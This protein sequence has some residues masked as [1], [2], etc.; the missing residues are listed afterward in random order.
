MA[1]TD[2]GMSD[3][4]ISAYLDGELSSDERQAVERA[5]QQ[6]AACRQLYDQLRALR[7]SLQGLP[8]HELEPEFAARV[9]QRI[10]EIRP[11][12]APQPAP[13]PAPRGFR[14]GL[15]WAAVAIA[16]GVAVMLL[17]PPSE[18]E[19]HHVVQ[20]PS[21]KNE[22]AK[23]P[24]SVQP[25]DGASSAR[26]ADLAGS[27]EVDATAV[28]PQPQSAGRGMYR[29]EVPGPQPAAERAPGQAGVAADERLERLNKP[30]APASRLGQEAE[31]LPARGLVEFKAQPAQPSDDPTVVPSVESAAARSAGQ[32]AAAGGVSFSTDPPLD[33]DRSPAGLRV[34]VTDKQLTALLARLN[35]EG[36][37]PM[38][39][40]VAGDKD[41]TLRERVESTAGSRLARGTLGATSNAKTRVT[42]V[43]VAGSVDR[44][45]SVLEQWGFRAKEVTATE[46]DR[47][48][49]AERSTSAAVTDAVADIAAAGPELAESKQPLAAA[50]G[51]WLFFRHLDAPT[52]AAPTA[53][54]A[55]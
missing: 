34:D 36:L 17:A 27:L 43:R 16:A 8:R 45:R 54:P 11:D 44:V 23:A 2:P 51:I 3:E 10:A 53:E 12:H 52:T 20:A 15:V 18:R 31:R 32:S 42:R 21:D 40:R 25:A 13:V 14:R 24:Q 41:A 5:M 1:E 39:E 9:L 19:R 35:A 48:L 7:E 50:A 46:A 38:E 55:R 47:Y 49:A 37:T 28:V 33:R 30:Q 26:R 29:D 22:L 4:M 6:D